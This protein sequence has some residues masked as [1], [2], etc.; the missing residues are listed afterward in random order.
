LQ[1][2][3]NILKKKIGT[4]NLPMKTKI[5]PKKV[6]LSVKE[7]SGFEFKE[8][9]QLFVSP[10]KEY[11]RCKGAKNWGYPTE[12]ASSTQNLKKNYRDNKSI[13]QNENFPKK[14]MFSTLKV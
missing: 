11:K 8:Q 6:C 14:S 2:R 4:S 10:I 1:A 7:L 13:N 12:F 5:F 9:N 3:P